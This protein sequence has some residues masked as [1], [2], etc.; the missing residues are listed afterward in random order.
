[1]CGDGVTE[2]LEQCD[3][4]NDV[5]GD[6]CDIDCTISLDTSVWQATAGG[7]AG[8]QDVGHGIVVD[9][10]GN[11]IAV[12][13]V[14]DAVGD[15]DIWVR[16]YDPDG[17]ELWTAQLDPS[18]GG[19]DRAYAV[20]VDAA[21]NLYVTGE[22]DAAPAIADIWVGQLASDGTP[23][24]SATFDGSASDNDGGRGIAV[25]DAGNVVVTGF[26][27]VGTNDN[28]IFVGRWGAGGGAPQWTDVVP[29]PGGL[30]DRGRGVVLDSAGDIIV[31]GFVAKASFDRDVWLRKYGPAGTEQWTQTWDS[32]ADDAGFGIAVAPD[33]SVAVSG[34]TPVIATNQDVWL[35]KY[36]SAGDLVWFK[37][38]GA[39]SFLN[40]NGLGVASDADGNFV[41][42]GFKSLSNT[43][44]D[45]WLRKYD[46]GGG[47]V[48]TQAV[49]GAGM[50]AD[51]AQ[52][53]ASDAAGDFVVVGEIRVDATN[54]GDIWVGK[55]AAD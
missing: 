50:V 8:I 7:T 18:A 45:I 12:G 15:P 14:S 6:G 3:D 41:V 10:A 27:K 28:D 51:E 43:D 37:Q 30:D 2:D 26:V 23:G 20:A 36:S 1:V 13:Y 48:W 22:T 46:A 5:N 49:A 55:F 40:D 4:G 53:I 44:R 42:A 34:M 17:N 24:W 47:V 54:N 9:H 16:K 35:G 38:F 32:G 31:A 29:G 33:D 39:P 52:G 21:D 25:D 11:I 19:E